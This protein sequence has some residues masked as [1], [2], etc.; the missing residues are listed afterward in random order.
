MQLEVKV[1]KQN[2]RWKVTGVKGLAKKDIDSVVGQILVM[3]GLTGDT[4]LVFETRQG[5]ETYSVAD[6]SN[7]SARALLSEK[8]R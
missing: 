5:Y 4:K 1:S 3:P 2:R 6:I 7:D 8:L